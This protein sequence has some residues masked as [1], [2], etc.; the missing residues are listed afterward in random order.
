MTLTPREIDSRLPVLAPAKAHSTYASRNFGIDCLRGLAI[1]LVIVH[2]LALPFRLPLGPSLVGEWLPKRLI[3]AIGRN[4]QV[5]TCRIDGKV[6][7]TFTLCW[8]F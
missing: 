5:I 1:L 7:R 2:H 8:N 6:P 3:E 4:Q